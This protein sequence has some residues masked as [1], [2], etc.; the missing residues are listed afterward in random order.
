MAARAVK[1]IWDSAKLTKRGYLDVTDVTK[2]AVKEHER[3][4]EMAQ[5]AV[6]K[7]THLDGAEPSTPISRNADSV[8][9]DT[10]TVVQGKDLFNKIDYERL[11]AE[12][13]YDHKSSHPRI[14][15]EIYRQQGFDG[16]PMLAGPGGV[17]AVIAS[18][19]R[20][21]FRGVSKPEYVQSF[22]TGTY[23]A[24]RGVSGSGTYVTT[25]EFYTHTYDHKMRMALR[26]GVKTASYAELKAEREAERNQIYQEMIS[27][28]DHP[29]RDTADQLEKLKRKL[30]VLQDMGRFAAIRGYDAYES[31][32]TEYYWVVLNRTALVVER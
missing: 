26:P 30:W 14:M 21:L 7:D 31:M 1:G 25:D 6:P 5:D 10:A 15:E 8:A 18:G 3:A 23:F 11:Y 32:N 17:D 24:G 16:L 19:G 27:L 13:S 2:V 22:K 12:R 20:E 29:S 9:V 4:E 28:E